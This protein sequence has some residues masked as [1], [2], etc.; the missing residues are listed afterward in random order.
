MC[1]KVIVITY[2][3][4][5]YP[6]L[7]SSYS[8]LTQAKLISITNK[9]CKSSKI[10]LVFTSFKI[11]NFFSAKNEIPSKLKS[12]VVYRFKCASCNACYIGETSCHFKTRIDE[13]IKKDK[14]SHIYKYLHST[15]GCFDKYNN[16]CLSILDTAT[17]HFQLK[18]KEGLYIGWENPILN[19]Q[20]KHLVSALGI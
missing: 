17:T 12:R 14:N 8:N 3:I 10:K 16:D 19:K 18:L 11:K 4:L 13:H 7:V 15:E 1:V 9:F 2:S 5:N 20:V 6:T